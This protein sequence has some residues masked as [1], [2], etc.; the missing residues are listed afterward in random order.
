LFQETNGNGVSHRTAGY[1]TF[2]LSGKSTYSGKVFLDGNSITLSGKF[3]LSGRSTKTLLRGAKFGKSDLSLEMAL[4]WSTDSQMFFGT[5]GDGTW[6]SEIIGDRAGFSLANPAATYL[7]RYT[8]VLPRGENYPTTSPGGCGY[9]LITN[10]VDGRIVLGGRLG[11]NTIISQN[12]SLSKDGK[13]PL[14]VPLYKNTNIFING[15]TLQTATNKSDMRGLLFGWVDFTSSAAGPTGSLDWIKTSVPTT[16]NL[17]TN[18]FYT[19]GF[20]NALGIISSPYNPPPSGNRIL[21][22][23]NSTAIFSHG[24]LAAPVAWNASVA[25]NNAVSVTYIGTNKVTLT[26]N[27]KTGY[28]SGKFPHVNND[29]LTTSF[30]GAVLQQQNYAAGE[31]PGRTDQGSTTNQTGSVVLQGN[32]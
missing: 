19:A 14:Y 5:I 21:Q 16:N 17:N 1:I 20:T 24:N 7:G 15:V 31:F 10:K 18:Y 4:D 23:T 13:W 9:G 6:S 30:Y 25:S 2:K 3:D 12:V 11:D 29:N 27:A 8:M 22:F 28:M 26:L 32:D